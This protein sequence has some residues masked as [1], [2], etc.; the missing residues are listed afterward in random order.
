MELAEVLVRV[1]PLAIA[2]ALSPVN[3]SIV[4]LMLLS[5]NHPIARSLSFIAGFVV[6]LALIGTFTVS[7]FTSFYVPPPGPYVSILILVLGGVLILLGVRQLVAHTDPDQPP[8]AWMRE[9][10]KLG[11][12]GAFWVG[13]LLSALGLKTIA[14]YVTCLG[15]ITTSAI[16]IL[17]QGLTIALVIILMVAT[18]IIPVIV[19][20]AEPRRGKATLER[21]RTWM[22][23]KQHWVAGGVLVV[24]GGA[25]ILLGLQALF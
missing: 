20:L 25:V 22:V 9:I 17:Q 24:A 14:I 1:I 15:I 5:E 3:V 10:V 19:F 16:N 8:A 23:E 21:M 18:M 12:F 6:A 7:L 13:I 2:G 4:I 11:P